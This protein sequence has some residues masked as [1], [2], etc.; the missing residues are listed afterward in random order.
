MSN[1]AI[2]D[3]NTVRK[4]LS[5][6]VDYFTRP[7]IGK[8]EFWELMAMKLSTAIHHEPP[9]TWRYVQ[10]VYKGSLDPSREFGRAVEILGAMVDDVPQVVADTEQVS[11]YAKPGTIKAGAIVMG[12]S[13]MCANPS[14]KVFFVPNVP[15]R[16]L[17]PICS[18][19]SNHKKE[20]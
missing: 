16:K 19:R 7:E 14:C 3:P 11:V 13:K 8:V 1:E 6:L 12:E 10:G 5:E 17:C 9:W 15:W 2:F 4:M 18:P 20:S